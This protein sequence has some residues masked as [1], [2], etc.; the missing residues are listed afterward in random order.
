MADSIQL[1]AA[2]NYIAQGFPVFPCC[3]TIDGKCE[4]GRGHQGRDIGKVPLTPH[5]L[6]D[7]T[8][9]M[10]RA[11]EYWAHWPSANV[12]IAIPPTHFV[13][14]V[15]IEHGGF[16][17]LSK[18]QEKYD[19]L[20][21]TWLVITGSGGQHYWYKTNTPIR[22]TTGL[23][24]LPGLDIRGT[25][26]YV[27]APPSMHRSG[28]R[29]ETSEIWNG[30]IALAPKWLIDICSKTQASQPTNDGSELPIPEGQRND[31][32]TRDAGALRRRGLSEKAIAAALLIE[33]RERCQPPLPED[34]V[35]RIAKSVC[36]Y[37]P[38][39]PKVRRPKYHHGV[40]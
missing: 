26:G 30:P 21:T 33:N 23:D 39:E 5:G 28:H 36:R 19:A 22:N 14:D 34:E 13:L 2:L 31:T 25:G 11:R 35:Y 9:M 27:I 4:C 16:E 6:K 7:A 10:T 1:K 37:P 17:S 40:P 32:L 24:G 12:A 3:W 20:P 8:L 18:L 38:E 15:D 29:Y